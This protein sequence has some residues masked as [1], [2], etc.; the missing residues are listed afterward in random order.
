LIFEHGGH[1]IPGH[2][3]LWI[4]GGHMEFTEIR[5]R[6]HFLSGDGLPIRT[7]CQLARISRNNRYLTTL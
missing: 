7:G 3:V 2:R 6:S 4:V 5:D 1:V